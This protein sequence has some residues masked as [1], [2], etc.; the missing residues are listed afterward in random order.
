M[1]NKKYEYVIE[2]ISN[3][4]HHILRKRIMNG[5]QLSL[6]IYQDQHLNNVLNNIHQEY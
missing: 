1:D 3:G 6:S 2:S 4:N 5:E